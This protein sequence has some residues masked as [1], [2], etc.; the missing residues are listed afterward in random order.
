MEKKQNIKWWWNIPIILLIGLLVPLGIRSIV[1]DDN[2]FG[3]GTF[4]KQTTFNIKYYW[5]TENE[6]KLR[7]K[8]GKELSGRVRRKIARRGSTRYSSGALES[9]VNNYTRFIYLNMPHG[10]DIK[11]FRA[12]VRYKINSIYTPGIEQSNKNLMVI[13]YP[14]DPED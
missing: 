14:R 6:K 12:E 11:S 10:E 7:Y 9:W 5:I 8:P 4:S 13:E 3:W 2:R 1:T